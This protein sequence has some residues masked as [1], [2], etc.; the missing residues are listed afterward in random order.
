MYVMYSHTLPL[1]FKMNPLPGCVAE[2]MMCIRPTLGLGRR[3]VG[4]AHEIKILQTDDI[5]NMCE[6]GF[7]V[8]TLA[9]LKAAI[10]RWSLLATSV[11]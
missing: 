10:S 4:G 6:S 3:S 5:S 9:A 2:D 11:V 7:F 8:L 1:L